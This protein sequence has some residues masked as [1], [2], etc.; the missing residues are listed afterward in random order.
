MPNLDAKF[1]VLPYKFTGEGPG[2]D[3]AR[4]FSCMG[5]HYDQRYEPNAKTE[6]FTGQLTEE[7][8]LTFLKLFKIESKTKDTMT[9][10]HIFLHK[11]TSHKYTSL[12]TRDECETLADDNEF[13]GYTTN[14]SLPELEFRIAE[15]IQERSDFGLMATNGAH[16]IAWSTYY[17]KHLEHYI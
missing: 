1:S 10:L 7:D 5:L 11:Y 6:Y 15:F 3:N 2:N 12:S 16:R 9:A 8:V 13:V 4:L 14:M 17:G